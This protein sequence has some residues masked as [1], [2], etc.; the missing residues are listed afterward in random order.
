MRVYPEKT[1]YS[2]PFIKHVR[3]KYVDYHISFFFLLLHPSLFRYFIASLDFMILRQLCL[4]KCCH[5]YFREAAGAAAS[6]SDRHCNRAQIKAPRDC[7]FQY[8]V[9]LNRSA[10]AELSII[11]TFK[12]EQ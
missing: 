7:Q 9:Y 11:I 6:C 2:C 5:V 8:R 1:T 10:V 3:E 12:D 4:I